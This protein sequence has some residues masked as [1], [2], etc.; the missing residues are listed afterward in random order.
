MS[1]VVI[2]ANQLNKQWFSRPYAFTQGQRLA[3]KPSRV[4]MK[5]LSFIYNY[6]QHENVCWKGYTELA[7]IL[8]CSKS[9][10]GAVARKIADGEFPGFERLRKGMEKS[11]YVYKGEKDL[12]GFRTEAWLRSIKFKI[13]RNTYERNAFEFAQNGKKRRVLKTSIWEER[14]LRSCEEDVF[15]L[16]YSYTLDPKKR[17][18]EGTVADIAGKLDMSIRSAEA[19]ISS[20]MSCELIFRPLKGV[21]GSTARA[22]YVANL[23]LIRKIRKG[24]K[25]KKKASV[26]E[27]GTSEYIRRVNA[28][29]ERDRKESEE[30]NAMLDRIDALT[31]HAQQF[32]RFNAIRIELKRINL[33]I[34]KACIAGADASSLEARKNEL[35][36]EMTSLL[37]RLGI[38]VALFNFEN[39]EW[40]EEKLRE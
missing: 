3:R 15:S 28:H 18:F 5:V 32:P 24:S 34:V 7:S 37:A 13:R 1:D 8:H 19:A 12:D 38:D 33:N 36:A 14:E 17:C 39:A 2:T 26:Q 9:S 35:C 16:I 6:A 10:I 4:E 21:N 20:I 30:K 29:A 40:N 22:K 11:T 23:D 31:A 25:K 27:Q